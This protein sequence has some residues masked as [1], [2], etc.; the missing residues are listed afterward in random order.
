[1]LYHIYY[2]S[3]FWLLKT[4]LGEFLKVKIDECNKYG[5]TWPR[6]GDSIY[7]KT[8]YEKKLLKYR[9]ILCRHYHSKG[10]IRLIQNYSSSFSIVKRYVTWLGSN[11]VIKLLWRSI[12]LLWRHDVRLSYEFTQQTGEEMNEFIL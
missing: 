1:M 6:M 8:K 4:S 9:T 7:T 5:I 3:H 11:D 10:V 12:K 2:T